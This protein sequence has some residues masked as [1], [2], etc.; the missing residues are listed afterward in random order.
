MTA[1]D[2]RKQTEQESL[3][4]LAL[5]YLDDIYKLI[6]KSSKGGFITVPKNSNKTYV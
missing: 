4:Y 1:N 3:I 6:N 5:G 2:A